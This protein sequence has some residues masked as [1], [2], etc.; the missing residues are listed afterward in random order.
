MDESDYILESIVEGLER[1]D[2]ASVTMKLHP[3][4]RKT[5]VEDCGAGQASRG[6]GNCSLRVAKEKA[7]QKFKKYDH[8]QIAKQL[9]R[10]MSSFTGDI[11]A[12][13]MGSYADLCGGIKG[14]PLHEYELYIRGE[15]E[16]AWYPEATLTLIDNQG[17]SLLKQWRKEAAEMRLPSPIW[18]GSSRTGQPSSRPRSGVVCRRWRTAWGTADCGVT[19]SPLRP[20]ISMGR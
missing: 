3:T 12:V 18:I 8:V 16:V 9:P 17:K 15:E 7:M 10:D 1:P 4:G 5:F 14:R 19:P 11:D 13:V 20:P 2:S 6:Q